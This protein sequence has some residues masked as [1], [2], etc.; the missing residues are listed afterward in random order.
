MKISGLSA[1]IEK[2][3][4]DGA[5]LPVM[6]EFYTI[7]GEGTHTG[8]A[9]W[10]IRIGGCD[11]GCR[12]CDV[13]ESWNPKHFPPK[14]TH[15]V[16]EQAAMHKANTVVVTGGEPLNYNLDLLTNQLHQKGIKCHIETS[17]SSPLSGHWDWICLSPKRNKAP[18]KR[19]FTMANELKVIIEDES[20]LLWAEENAQSV[21][22]DCEL[23][24][25]PEWSKK[26]IITPLIIDYILKNNQW[27]IS[28]QSHK[29]M[30]IP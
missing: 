17:G 19:I 16:V 1:D 12:W 11:V 25:Q 10:F 27:K 22:K 30:H 2:Q 4:N 23:F 20:D 15:L 18:I 29:F 5:V 24:L 9:A 14:A 13:K 21:H 3:L 7:Q 28:I 8:K 6:E 26:D